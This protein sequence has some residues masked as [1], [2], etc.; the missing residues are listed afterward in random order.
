MIPAVNRTESAQIDQGN[1]ANAGEMYAA[2][3]G[4]L[5]ADDGLCEAVYNLL[6]EFNRGESGPRPVPVPK[7]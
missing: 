7:P 3:C 6:R 1:V 2:V 4:W 5:Q